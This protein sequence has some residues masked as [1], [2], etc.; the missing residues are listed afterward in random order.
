LAESFNMKS[1]AVMDE[2]RRSLLDISQAAIKVTRK[3]DPQA[4]GTASPPAPRRSNSKRN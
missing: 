2:G 4:T 1:G 3:F